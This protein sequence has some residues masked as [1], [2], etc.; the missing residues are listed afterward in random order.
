M[1]LPV[2]DT[3]RV[4]AMPRRPRDPRPK[5]DVTR[6]LDALMTRMEELDAQALDAR[7]EFGRA[8]KAARDDGLTQ[9]EIVR[10]LDTNRELLRRIQRRAEDADR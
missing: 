9:D 4:T 5:S 6:R 7:L 3:G 8:M 1:T 2:C 10:E